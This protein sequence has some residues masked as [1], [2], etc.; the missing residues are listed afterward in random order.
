MK[1]IVLTQDRPQHI[2]LTNKLC[3]NVPIERIVV[4]DTPK[5]S[6]QQRTRQLFR[7]YGFLKVMDRSFGTLINSIMFYP[8]KKKAAMTNLFGTS[9]CSSFNQLDLVERI[10]G[11]NSEKCYRYIKSLYPDI[12]AVYGTPIVSDRILNIPSKIALNMHTGISPYYRGTDCAFW[13]VYNQELDYLGATVHECTSRVD[14]GKIYATGKALLESQDSLESIFPRCV[15][16]GAFLYVKVLQNW[17]NDP[18]AVQGHEQNLQEGKEYRAHMKT[19]RH[20][21]KARILIR[22]GI[23]RQ[24]ISGDKS[25][26]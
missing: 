16:T 7:R 21:L 25:N 23:I 19:W 2:Y 5:V 15:I 4:V 6:K 11:V 8:A 9:D 18:T 13:P 10:T 12:I 20:E 3:R 26:E 22:N 24:Y 1:I 14:G 17:I